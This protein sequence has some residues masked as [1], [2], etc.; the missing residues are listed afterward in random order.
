MKSESVQNRTNQ[1][2]GFAQKVIC[3]QHN[4][5]SQSVSTSDIS[6]TC[7][8]SHISFGVF[9]LVLMYTPSCNIIG[10]ILGPCTAG[11]M[12]KV[13]GFLFAIIASFM[14]MAGNLYE[15]R[16]T[17][18]FVGSLGIFLI[19]IGN[20][21]EKKINSRNNREKNIAKK[22]RHLFYLFLVFPFLVIFSPLILIFLRFMAFIKPSN[23]FIRKQNWN[24]TLGYKGSTRLC[25]QFFQLFTNIKKP[26]SWATWVSIVCLCILNPLTI[27]NIFIR[28]GKGAQGR[29]H[30]LSYFVFFFNM[31]SRALMVSVV[32]TFY[33]E[34]SWFLLVIYCWIFGRVV[35]YSIQNNENEYEMKNEAVAFSIVG[36]T[37]FENTQSSKMLRG[38]SSF[39]NACMTIFVFV[40]IRQKRPFEN[41]ENLFAETWY[42]LDMVM[43]ITFSAIFLSILL[44]LPGNFCFMKCRRESIFFFG[45]KSPAPAPINQSIELEEMKTTSNV[46]EENEESVKEKKEIN[47]DMLM[48]ASEGNL[49]L[50]KSLIKA[51]ADTSFR[52]EDSDTGLHISARQGHTRIVRTFL[53]D[54]IDVNSRGFNGMTGLM[55]AAENNYPDI[56]SDLLIN[57][58]TINLKDDNGNTAADYARLN[59]SDDVLNVFKVWYNHLWHN[60]GNLNFEMLEAAKNGNKRMVD[61]LISAGADIKSQYDSNS[62]F[63]CRRISVANFGYRYLRGIFPEERR[64]KYQGFTGL[65]IAAVQGHDE[66]VK[67]FLNRGIDVNIKSS[68]MTALTLAVTES[69]SSSVKVLVDHGALVKVS[70]KQEVQ[71]LLWQEFEKTREENELENWRKEQEIKKK[72][73]KSV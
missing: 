26:S 65:H 54:S 53:D 45:M 15:L 64:V 17:A 1:V 68:G 38:I 73:R 21:Q 67:V 58:A 25:F 71:E 57:G 5:S 19:I 6:Y 52:N 44:D 11:L 23:E 4:I 49:K 30:F 37:N 3:V 61:C 70:L 7:S 24:L 50:V 41:F 42:L 28:Q 34:E 59:D 9:L 69:N 33:G 14:W 22:K 20:I 62:V 8:E 10:A 72:Q 12:S 43:I 16:I 60:P 47:T 13:W 66:V 39:Y 18:A 31:L 56:L 32:V 2:F 46:V 51:G 63:A 27:R 29:K 48:A 35:R 36:V 40:C 55:I